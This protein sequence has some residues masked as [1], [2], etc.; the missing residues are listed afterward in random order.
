MKH[1]MFAM[2]RG[3]CTE[4]QCEGQR[5]RKCGNLLTLDLD[6]RRNGWFCINSTCSSPLRSKWNGLP[7]GITEKNGL[8][9]NLIIE[10]EKKTP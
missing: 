7:V 2:C 10:Q 1:C 8:I 6:P 4:F 9:N 5:C 3:N